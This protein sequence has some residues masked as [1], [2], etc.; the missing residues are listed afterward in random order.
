MDGIKPIASDTLPR[1]QSKFSLIIISWRNIANIHFSFK[2]IHF[3]G[4][5]TEVGGN[6]HEIFEDPRTTGHKV[7]NPKD[8]QL[9]LEALFN[10]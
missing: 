7:E 8:T 1:E 3:F 10:L 6:D 2:E 4:D 5:K 9:Q